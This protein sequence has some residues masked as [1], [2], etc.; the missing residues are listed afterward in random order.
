[1]SKAIQLSSD[2]QS[3]NVDIASILKQAQDDRTLHEEETKKDSM[4][5]QTLQEDKDIMK[6]D[7]NML[8]NEDRK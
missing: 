6:K 3:I 8:Q 4:K 5:K 7:E 2:I 1:M